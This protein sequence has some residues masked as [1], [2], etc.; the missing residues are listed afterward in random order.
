MSE[1][2]GRCA[3]EH[4]DYCCPP[5]YL[6]KEGFTCRSALPI[7]PGDIT[8]KCG[9]TDADLMTEEEY[10]EGLRAMKQIVN[11]HAGKRMEP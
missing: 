7:Q 11:A 6:V 4:E 8:N 5:D 9:A 3:F 1:S 10:E 2:N